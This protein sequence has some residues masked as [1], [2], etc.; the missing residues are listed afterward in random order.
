MRFTGKPRRT[1]V[2]GQTVALDGD[3]V[4]TPRGR[5]LTP[6]APATT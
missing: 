3:I 5:L 1:M 2:R 6:A 4:G